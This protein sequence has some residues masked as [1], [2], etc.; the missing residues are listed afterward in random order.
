M[1]N[2]PS[3]VE[4]ATIPA[5]DD[6]VRA[7][8]VA[9]FEKAEQSDAVDSASETN[10]ASVGD[11]SAVEGETAAEKKLRNPYKDPETGKFTSAP[12][13]AAAKAPVE[14][15]EITAPEASPKAP[16]QAQSNAPVAGPPV[17]WAADAKS[18]WSKLSPA[19]QTAVLKREREMSDGIRQYSETTRRYEQVLSPVQQEAQRLGLNVDQAIN[20]LMAAHHRLNRDPAGAIAQLAQQYGVDLGTLTGQSNGAASSSPIVPQQTYDPRV[21]QMANW[22]ASQEQDKAR[23]VEMFV[24]E[25]ARSPGHEHFD[26]VQ[27]ELLALVPQI[28]ANNP[29]WPHEKILQDAYDRSVWANPTTRAQVIENQRQEDETK[30]IAAQKEKVNNAK[31][32]S[33]SVTGSSTSSGGSA[34]KGT[35][36]EELE[37]AFA[38][39]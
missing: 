18:E 33:S 7:S 30:R 34:P 1:D 19:T 25:F 5:A 37:A 11:K 36:R 31:R 16:E 2:S 6:S 28:K 3:Q 39:R 10:T 12:K 22:I 8:L 27:N 38:A 24:D 35:V 4:N 23:S 17:S 9:E 21:D 26:S 20:S 14:A 13:E 29:S 32:A 15:K